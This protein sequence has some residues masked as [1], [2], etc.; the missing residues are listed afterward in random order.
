MKFVL[1][2]RSKNGLNEAAKERSKLTI[3]RHLN[4]PRK[5]GLF[6]GGMSKEEVIGGIK[7]Q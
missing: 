2:I 1:S 5:N 6:G 3:S 7:H 4:S